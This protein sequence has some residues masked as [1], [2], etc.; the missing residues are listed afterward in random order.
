M[1]LTERQHDSIVELVNIAYGRAAA[2]LSTLT[3]QR[4]ILGAPKITLHQVKELQGLFSS[5]ITGEVATVHQIFS[6]SVSGNAML[7]LDYEG[8]IALSGLMDEHRVPVKQLTDSDLEVIAEL[9]NIL[10]NACLGTF[11]NI[12]QVHISFSVPRMQ[13][14]SLTALMDSLVIGS[15]ELKYALAVATNF[16]LR[17]S[18]VGGF[19]VIVLGVASLDS[20]I[21]AVEKLG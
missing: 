12:L 18:A 1:K 8:A 5:N 15:Q 20:L 19:L 14:D 6:G 21:Q 10:L 3:G 7:V 2:S 16:N 9:G 13:V 4:V 11:G 17:D